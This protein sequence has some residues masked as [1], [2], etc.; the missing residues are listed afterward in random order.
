MNKTQA[1]DKFFSY[2]VVYVEDEPFQ[3][4]INFKMKNEYYKDMLD[5]MYELDDVSNV[6]LAISNEYTKTIEQFLQFNNKEGLDKVRF[7]VYDSHTF[8]MKCPEFFG[9]D[10]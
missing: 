2:L 7:E 4:F 5:Q 3:F 9:E 6:V 1:F 8:M 10:E